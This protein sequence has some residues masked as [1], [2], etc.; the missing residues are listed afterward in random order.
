MHT[1]SL[2]VR[3]VTKEAK[4]MRRTIAKTASFLSSNDF[5]NCL[6]LI[7][8]PLSMSVVDSSW[9]FTPAGYIDPWVNVAYFL[10][11]SD[12]TFLNSYYKIARLSWIIP[13]FIAYKIFTPLVATYLLHIACLLVSILF[14]Y[15]TVARLFG[16]VIAFATAA[17]F[18]S[19]V[20]FHGS[21][22]WDYQ[23][24]PAGAY[25]VL[26]FY[27]LTTALMSKNSR[28]R[29]IGAG[30][31]YAAAG[32]A[33]IGFVNMAPLLGFHFLVL[34]RHRFGKLPSWRFILAAALWVIFGA[35]VLTVLLG[36][37]NAA[38]GR[39]FLFFKILLD[40][41]TSLVR[42]SSGQSA[43]WLPWSSEWFLSVPA[44][45]YLGF[46]AAVLVGCII[47]VLL[48]V[49]RKQLNPIA[50]SFQLQYLFV[51][52]LWITW[53]SAGQTALQPDYFAYPLYPVMFFAIAGLVANWEWTESPRQS[54]LVFCL[55]VAAIIITSLS[56]PFMIDTLSLWANE[57]LQFFLI[58]SALLVVGLFPISRG[59]PV[60]LVA[61]VLAFAT[62]NAFG[63]GGSLN[64][65][66][67]D[68]TCKDAK[69]ANVALVESA[70]FLSRFD[71]NSENMFVWWDRSEALQNT[72]GCSMRIKNFAVALASLGFGY[73][74]DPWPDMPD[75]DELPSGSFT[76][77]A[78]AQRIAVP[79]ANYKNIER[80]IARYEQEGV[81]LEIESQKTI[82]TSQFTFNLYVLRG[83]HPH[84]E[85]SPRRGL[86][87]LQL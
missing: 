4:G 73:L 51:C 28:A 83:R 71:L 87:R 86:F 61:A 11:Y 53:Q 23:N 10:H 18:A 48:A 74:A 5:R 69:S 39:D 1:K 21:G 59:R 38:V 49:I 12:P 20:P 80:V 42:D 19:F 15:L 25:Y 64:Q 3:G 34:Y 57:H 35:L 58:A 40:K 77:I 56:F 46:S 16:S 6:L 75:A 30:A 24:A 33:T 41:V 27:L 67:L 36:L 47:S 66:R 84:P 17:C 60:L 79:T 14:F 82:N 45:R 37:A 81:P 44:L 63:A 26:A 8:I 31:A 7:A 2:P 32:H 70:L 85:A 22:G 65:Y 50:L 13:G 76:L 68:E 9:L 29:L 72:S 78:G 43:W 54:T 62:M 52:I 55:F